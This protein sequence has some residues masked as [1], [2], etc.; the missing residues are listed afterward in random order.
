MRPFQ[1]SHHCCCGHKQTQEWGLLWHHTWLCS[2][3]ALPAKQHHSWFMAFGSMFTAVQ[4]AS[5]DIVLPKTHRVDGVDEFSGL[6]ELHETLPQVVE[7]TFHQDLLL[8]VVVQKVVPQRLLGQGLG[9]SHNDHTISVP[10]AQ[11][12]ERLHKC[13]SHYMETH[14]DLC[15]YEQMTFWD[16]TSHESMQHWGGGDRWGNRCPG[17]RWPSHKTGW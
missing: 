4:T 6:A 11:N 9:V 1:I 10:R 7:R 16:T 15:S 12:K 5:G 3:I 13:P 2:W 17:A 14:Q 8:L